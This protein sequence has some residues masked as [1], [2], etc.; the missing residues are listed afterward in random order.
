MRTPSGMG[1]G[2]MLRAVGR[3]VGAGVG[4]V[5]EAI[6]TG[7]AG[8][9]GKPARI[10]CVASS[11]ASSPASASSPTFAAASGRVPGWS[12]CAC[13]GDGDEWEA[14]GEE[15]LEVEE[16][17]E[18]G[19]W[20]LSERL[21][22]GRA[23]SKEEVEEAVSSLQH[24]GMNKFEVV[25]K[26]AKPNHFNCGVFMIF[27]PSTFSQTTENGHPSYLGH[28]AVDKEMIPTTPQKASSIES[29]T[30]SESDWIEPALHLYSSNTFQSKEHEKVFDAFR[31]LQINPSIQRM[32]ASLSSD[33]AVWDAVMKNEI[34]I[35]VESC[36][37]VFFPNP[38]DDNSV[39]NYETQSSDEHPDVTPGILRWI[40][41]GTK[42]KLMEFIH[43]ITELVG[44]LFHLQEKDE[45][46]DLFNHAVRSSFMLSVAV[47]IIVVVTRIQ[48]A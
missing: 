23:P 48:K 45:N 2:K 4:G 8:R 15:E 34:G 10:V 22:F 17:G 16:E 30:D 1:G 33:E 13:F 6:A 47:F 32:V 37:L 14:V 43:N 5:K 11:G 29:L 38:T 42:S 26:L 40:L 31:L 9:P 28:V 3:V 44:G 18:L 25:I 21:V 19:K 41:D 12:S 46:P 39:G 7:G 20:G 36:N 35:D 24:T 27:V